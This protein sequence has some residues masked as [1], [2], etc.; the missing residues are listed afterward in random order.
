MLEKIREK[1]F[2]KPVVKDADYL[3]ELLYKEIVKKYEKAIRS[4]RGNLYLP[5]PEYDVSDLV[6]LEDRG[7]AVI[8]YRGTSFIEI[9]LKNNLKYVD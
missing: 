7:F 5:S 1:I 6:F 4:G 8:A 2:G 3:R 9:S